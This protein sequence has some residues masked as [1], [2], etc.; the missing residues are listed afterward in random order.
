MQFFKDFEPLTLYGRPTEVAR[1][2]KHVER[3][4]AEFD[5]ATA[6]VSLQMDSGCR[7]E[8]RSDIWVTFNL[9]L[10]GFYDVSEVCSQE[11]R[12]ANTLRA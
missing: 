3:D 1:Y 5:V 4:M 8:I 9:K 6:R 7:V 10:G 12:R 2:A 11:G